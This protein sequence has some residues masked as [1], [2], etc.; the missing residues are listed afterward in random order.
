MSKAEETQ[1]TQKVVKIKPKRKHII[2]ALRFIEATSPEDACKL[3]QLGLNLVLYKSRIE[4]LI[5][6]SVILSV[7]TKREDEEIELFYLDEEK[8]Q[9]FKTNEDKRF[10]ITIVSI[11]IPGFL[12]L[13]LGIAWLI[14]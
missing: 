6:N 7:S 12:L 2:D 14:L 4:H 9:A 1:E 3:E 13:L 8:Y 11:V 10:F 5:K